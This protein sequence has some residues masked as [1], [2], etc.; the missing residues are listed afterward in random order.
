MPQASAATASAS[1]EPAAPKFKLHPSVIQSTVRAK[2][3]LF[4]KCYEAGLARDP[5]LRGRVAA[6]FVIGKDGAVTNVTDDHS[7]MPDAEV[8]RCVLTAF[9]QIR[10]PKPEGDGILTVVYPIRLEPAEAERD[11]EAQPP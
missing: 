3:G 10:F 5:Q 4:R 11:A 9:Y 6:R 7:D 1:G 8:T 2:F